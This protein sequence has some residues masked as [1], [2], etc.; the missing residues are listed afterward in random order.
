[1]REGS[2]EREAPEQAS[3]LGPEALAFMRALGICTGGQCTQGLEGCD[4]G[5]MALRAW[6][7]VEMEG[8]GGPGWR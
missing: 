5:C 3:L 1:M 2:K 7:E 8:Q 4:P 6:V